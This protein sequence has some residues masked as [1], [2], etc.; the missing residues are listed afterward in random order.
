MNKRS[1]SET[2]LSPYFRY[3]GRTTSQDKQ[4]IKTFGQAENNQDK[5]PQNCGAHKTTSRKCEYCINQK[6]YPNY[7][8]ELRRERLEKEKAEKKLKKEMAEAYMGCLITN[9]PMVESHRMSK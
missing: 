8:H 6:K 9:V 2:Q 7:L 5:I 1:K 4:P 3:Q